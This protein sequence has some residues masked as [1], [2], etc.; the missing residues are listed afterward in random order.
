V[1][2]A[3]YNT[4]LAGIAMD[5]RSFFYVN[6]LEVWPENCISRTSKDHVKPV[7]QSWF[8]VACCPP[9]IARTLASLGEYIFL[10]D[11][12][13]IWIN[14]FISS[15]VRTIIQGQ[16][17]ELEMSTRFP[18][19]GQVTVSVN[20]QTSVI[21]RVYIRIPEYVKEYT[22]HING[23]ALEAKV[24][25]D[26]Y[27]AVETELTNT[28]ITLSFGIKPRFVRANPLVKEDVGRVAVMKGPLVFCMEE[29]DN[30]PNLPAYFLDTDAGLSEFYEENLLGGTSVIRCKGKKIRSEGWDT[31][32]LY[33]GRKPEFEDKD[34]TLVPY[35]YWGNR[36]TGEM[37][38][39]VKELF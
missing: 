35:P 39:W 7:R 25:E 17:V 1:E 32:A 18:N 24:G 6:P 29:V 31:E 11:Q 15:R 28:I 5:G 2:K 14:L 20:S 4:V 8:G 23:V 12:D 27:L 13:A 22:I 10:A 26:G 30:E 37:L 33:T 38:V 9:N 34:L 19:D 3:L 16:E 21:G 36:R